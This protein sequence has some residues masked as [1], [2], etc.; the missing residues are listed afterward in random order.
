MPYAKRDSD[1]KIT[2]LYGSSNAEAEEE[3]SSDDPEVSRFL[4][5]NGVGD[6]LKQLLSST[7][8]EFVRVL[9]DLI[10]VLV[11]KGVIMYTDLPVAA[12]RKL[13]RRRK[14]RKGLQPEPPIM[15]KESKIL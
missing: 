1:G 10:N 4:T 11:D 8:H 15:I 13:N 3:V 12:L 9:E 7:D 6:D 2:E 14:L 5:D